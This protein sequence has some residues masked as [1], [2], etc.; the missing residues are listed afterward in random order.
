TSASINIGITGGTDLATAMSGDQT[1]FGFGY[2]NNVV[3]FSPLEGSSVA[4]VLAAGVA[5]ELALVQ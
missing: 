5:A 4:G 1:P 2:T 3:G